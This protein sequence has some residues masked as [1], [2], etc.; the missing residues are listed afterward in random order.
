MKTGNYQYP[1]S[2]FAKKHYYEGL[3]KGREDALRAAVRDVC[4]LLTIEWT[5]ERAGAVASMTVAELDSL[6]TALLR[7]RRWP[8]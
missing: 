6:W 4:S 3:A 1:Q 7:D 8:G 5:G 2:D